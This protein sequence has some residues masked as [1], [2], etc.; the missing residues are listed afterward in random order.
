MMDPWG[1]LSMDKQLTLFYILTDKAEQQGVKTSFFINML[2]K[3]TTKSIPLATVLPVG[4]HVL[5]L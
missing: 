2:N 1:S 4:W 3:T 5:V